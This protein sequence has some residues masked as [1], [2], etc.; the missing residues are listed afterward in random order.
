MGFKFL[1]KI[2]RTHRPSARPPWRWATFWLAFSGGCLVIIGLVA[3]KDSIQSSIHTVDS[4]LSPGSKSP[5]FDL[6]PPR[7]S[8][9]SDPFS[10]RPQPRP[11][12]EAVNEF[13]R[14][15]Q[16][17]N[18]GRVDLLRQQDVAI[19]PVDF[20]SRCLPQWDFR[21]VKREV[22]WFYH[23]QSGVLPNGR[24]TTVFGVV[25]GLG[26]PLFQYPPLAGEPRALL[27]SQYL[28][29]KW[30]HLEEPRLALIATSNGPWDEAGAVIDLF[31]VNHPETQSS[32]RFWR[33]EDLSYPEQPAKSMRLVCFRDG[34]G[35][36][37]R[38]LCAFWSSGR[39]G[40]PG[41]PRA[42]WHRFDPALRAFVREP[43]A[44][45]DRLVETLQADFQR[46]SAGKK[47][48]VPHVMAAL[49]L[50]RLLDG[51]STI[52]GPGEEIENTPDD[53]D[54]DAAPSS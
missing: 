9:P 43:L 51:P 10:E 42:I 47:L 15:E 17:L 11:V 12:P 16:S 45:E 53:S 30:L 35:D 25:D 24:P 8:K 48:D 3:L 1:E 2:Q 26:K 46:V 7:D 18:S 34:N 19:D 4:E 23:Y 41:R 32:P 54:E 52:V 37:L 21:S 44:A 36:G 33:F 40:E 39:A 22:I 14:E 28:A 6:A 38:D 5:K 27:D 29:L 50:Q 49:A 31:L 20:T 13:L